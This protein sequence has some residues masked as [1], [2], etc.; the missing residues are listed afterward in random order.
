MKLKLSTIYAI[1][2]ILAAVAFVSV[3][4]ES[5]VVLDSVMSDRALALEMAAQY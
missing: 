2:L 5:H 1:G 3:K 4:D